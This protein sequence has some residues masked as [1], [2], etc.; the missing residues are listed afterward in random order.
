MSANLIP[1]VI[2]YL[3]FALFV[4]YLT[5]KIGALPLTVIIGTVMLMCL[6][7]FVRSIREE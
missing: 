1:A 3:L 6:Y 2:G 5:V 7:D 4:G